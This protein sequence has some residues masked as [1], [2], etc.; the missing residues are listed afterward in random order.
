MKTN[1]ALASVIG[2][3]LIFLLACNKADE[4]D[5]A[6]DNENI[7]AAK[8]IDAI[9]GQVKDLPAGAEVNVY[10]EGNASPMASVKLTKL[11]GFSYKAPAIGRYKV[12]MIK[13]DTLLQFN[14]ALLKPAD[15]DPDRKNDLYYMV[16]SDST[17]FNV[18]ANSKSQNAV[19]LKANLTGIRI[20]AV[21]V[22]GNALA[23]AS[24]CVYN[25]LD[26]Y[27]RNA[28]NCGGSIKY[29]QT[30]ASGIALLSGLKP[31]STYYINAKGKAGVVELNNSY[32]LSA[33]TFTSGAAQTI[34]EVEV[35]LK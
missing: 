27:Q 34:K 30:N 1:Y 24:L 29:L 28:P 12:V 22:L 11:G 9:S 33:Q 23:G 19:N 32:H 7:I 15:M 35:T 20:K 4:V 25:N 17:S 13:R 10:F 8:Y 5:F 18:A 6:G 21:D 14:A 31:N 26:F 3:L 16:Y 2:C